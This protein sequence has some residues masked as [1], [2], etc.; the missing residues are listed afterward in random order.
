MT[1]QQAERSVNALERCAAALEKIAV[2]FAPLSSLA[3]A[4]GPVLEEHADEIAK[5]LEEDIT[6]GLDTGP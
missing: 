6:S 5:A 2:V 4:L 1:S 3:Y